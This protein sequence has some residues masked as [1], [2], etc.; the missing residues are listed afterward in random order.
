[1][2]M[3]SCLIFAILLSFSS[4]YGG[5]LTVGYYDKKCP[6]AEATITDAV[7]KA[8]KNNEGLCAGILRLH[9]HDCFVRVMFLVLSFILIVFALTPSKVIIYVRSKLKLNSDIASATLLYI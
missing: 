1:M 2:T 9:F 8:V 4:A 3:Y 6:D 5:G 7:G